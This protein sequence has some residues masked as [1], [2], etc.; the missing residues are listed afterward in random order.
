[1]PNQDLIVVGEV[2]K[3]HGLAGEFSIVLHVYSPV[4]FDRA[5]R[6]YLRRI[7]QRRP[8]RVRVRSWREHNARVLLSLEEVA[9]RDEAELLRGAQILVRAEEL[10]PREDGEIF[11]QELIGAMILLPD[12]VALGR[13]QGVTDAG[14]QEV[15]S[16]MTDSGLEVLFPAHDRFILR[17]DLRQ[18]LIQ[19][20]PPPG[21]LELYL[22]ADQKSGC[23]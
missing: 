9:G 10:P 14:G 11:Q 3:P 7:G 19:V 20:D 22:G 5:S 1:M 4:F 13:I 23:D 12:G 8:R 2:A 6:F 18:G 21:L 16:I 15:W 17:V